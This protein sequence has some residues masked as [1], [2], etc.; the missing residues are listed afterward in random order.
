TLPLMIFW[1]LVIAGGL[2]KRRGRALRNPGQ[3]RARPRRPSRTRSTLRP[4]QDIW[5]DPRGAFLSRCVRATHGAILDAGCDAQNAQIA[6]SA[7]IASSGTRDWAQ[8]KRFWAAGKRAAKNKPGASWM[9][10]VNC[11]EG[12]HFRAAGV[13]LCLRGSR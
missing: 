10:R 7:I 8:V 13:K 3:L 2:I 5:D 12:V 6:K 9:R 4:A 11:G 1:S